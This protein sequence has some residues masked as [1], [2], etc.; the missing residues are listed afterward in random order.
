LDEIKEIIR[1]ALLRGEKILE[2]FIKDKNDLDQRKSLLSRYEVWHHNLF[3]FIS[4]ATIVKDHGFSE[5]II[6]ADPSR[7]LGTLPIDDLK[8]NLQTL[9]KLLAELKFV[10]LKRHFRPNDFKG[11][12]QSTRG[13]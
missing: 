11:I 5:K 7:Y 6:R 13:D 2:K 12:F 10:D 3:L 8:R 9:N 1:F 4:Q